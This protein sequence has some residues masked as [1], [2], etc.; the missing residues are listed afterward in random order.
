[1]I[2]NRHEAFA[3]HIELYTE[4]S[5]LSGI[6][7]GAKVQVAGMDAGQVIGVE[8]PDSPPAKFRVKLRI[9]EHE[10]EG[11]FHHLVDADGSGAAAESAKAYAAAHVFFKMRDQQSLEDGF[12]DYMQTSEFQAGIK[13]LIQAAKLEQVA[14]MCAEA[15]PWRSAAITSAAPCGTMAVPW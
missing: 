13:T 4:F 5:N 15:V 8:I 3:R 12:A 2:G 14:I 10:I 1:M 7:Q 11:A 6:A 9:T